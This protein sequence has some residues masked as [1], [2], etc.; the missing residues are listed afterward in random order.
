MTLP[1]EL[2]NPIIESDNQETDNIDS[3]MEQ[4]QEVAQNIKNN[5]RNIKP[6]PDKWKRKTSQKLRMNGE[7]YIG[8]QRKGNVVSQD[9]T[10]SARKIQPTCNSTFCKKSNS[11]FCHTF[12]ENQ[13]SEIFSSFW[14]AS[15]D[16][17][18]TL[19]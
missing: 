2:N 16:E 6:K 18:K 17:K 13:R 1:F 9:V 5:N 14:K 8:Y 7:D 19:V 15:W 3:N 4:V 11:R 10:R 12:E